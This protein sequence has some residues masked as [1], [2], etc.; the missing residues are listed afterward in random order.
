MSRFASA[1]LV[2]V[3]AALSASVPAFSSQRAQRL[4]GSTFSHPVA[5]SPMNSP[6]WKQFSMV[7]RSYTPSNIHAAVEGPQ[8]QLVWFA[9]TGA[10]SI[11]YIAI[12]GKVTTFAMPPTTGGDPLAPFAIQSGLLGEYYLANGGYGTINVTGANKYYCW[13]I[14]PQVTCP[15]GTVTPV[16][17]LS[18]PSSS[19]FAVSS[20]GAAWF[21]AWYWSQT[22]PPGASAAVVVRASGSSFTVNIISM[23]QPQQQPQPGVRNV[24]SGSD[25]NIWFL[26][27]DQITLDR[28]DASGTLTGY[29]LPTSAVDM[30]AGPD[31]NLWVLMQDNITAAVTL[32]KVTTSGV[33]SVFPVY[34]FGFMGT[35]GP[36]QP[37]GI[38]A[39]QDMGLWLGWGSVVL[40]FSTVAGGISEYA[41][42]GTMGAG[43][44]A[45]GA[46]GNMWMFPAFQGGTVA[47]VFL[48]G[49]ISA[50]PES[51]NLG[52]NQ[53]A[54]VTFGEQHYSGSF[55]ATSQG[56][57]KVSPVNG[58]RTFQVTG[59]GTGMC[60]VIATDVLNN[61]VAYV[62]VTVGGNGS[63]A[64]PTR[65]PV[66][67]RTVVR[68]SERD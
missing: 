4:P 25:G 60:W 22:F 52:L 64:R 42:P 58:A 27:P 29:G 44:V 34:P 56:P 28:L 67:R 19:T 63:H 31:G 62:A 8:K 59:T 48:M 53:T 1:L 39:G 68:I 51:L 32:A 38:V 24:V 17:G 41:V 65:L 54:P 10:N 2:G 26:D 55:V 14:S 20:D 12:G 3:F 15:P 6:E 45:P 5:S 13:I 18:L 16:P 7:T 47:S 57:C 30:A 36:P 46:D 43:A 61:G 35:G 23:Q 21:G 40:R 49:T 33:A 50:S 9:D 11:G 37:Q 66:H